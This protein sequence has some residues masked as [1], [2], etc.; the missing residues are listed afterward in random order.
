M[1]FLDWAIPLTRVVTKVMLASHGGDCVRGRAYKMKRA[2][3]TGEVGA[4]LCDWAYRC[5]D[6]TQSFLLQNL[7]QGRIR[8]DSWPTR[9]FAALPGQ[10]ALS[11][12]STVAVWRR[13]AGKCLT[14]REM[15]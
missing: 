9:D 10:Q 11:A 15:S 14:M 1:L 13:Q 4:I 2:W 12:R 8:I 5:S 6:K 3:G 7:S